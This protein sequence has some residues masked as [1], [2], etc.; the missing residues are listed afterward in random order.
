MAAQLLGLAVTVRPGAELGQ[1]QLEQGDGWQENY[2]PC[3]PRPA[4][5]VL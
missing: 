5:L 3:Y 4:S 1:R 2:F